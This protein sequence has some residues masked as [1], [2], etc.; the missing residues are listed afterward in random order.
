[1]GGDYFRAFKKLISESEGAR[2]SFFRCMSREIEKELKVYA[3]SKR[4]A[5]KDTTLRN[6]SSF[7]WTGFLAEVQSCLPC[8]Y[9]AVSAVIP[10]KPRYTTRG[11]FQIIGSVIGQLLF[12]HN[13]NRYKVLQKLNGIQVWAQGGSKKVL[14]YL[15]QFG[16]TMGYRSA[17]AA[18]K[19]ILGQYDTKNLH[20]QQQQENGSPVVVKAVAST[21]TRLST[22]EGVSRNSKHGKRKCPM[23][24]FQNEAEDESEEDNTGSEGDESEVH[25]TD[26]HKPA[27]S[28]QPAK[29]IP[30]NN[31]RKRPLLGLKKVAEEECEED[32]SEGKDYEEE[33]SEG[34][35]Y[36]E[37]EEDS[38]S[39][40]YEEEEE[41]THSN[42][43]AVSLQSGASV[44]WNNKRKYPLLDLDENESEEESEEDDSMDE[45]EVP[46]NHNIHR[47][48]VSVRP[49]QSKQR[50]TN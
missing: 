48:T 34:K 27:A 28:V 29:S 6:A 13:P 50:K 1:M 3:S 25:V 17:E 20:T 22:P 33:D 46:N 49:G 30:Q 31:N 45:D 7:D 44:A 10:S 35:D 9:Q 4:I 5:E 16:I 11:G 15:R 40:E 8:L 47:A 39:K 19:S 36:E 32:D 12:M 26:K 38:E 24:D 18:V 43:V 14:A 41:V 21:E 37:E 42:K 2:R 23:H